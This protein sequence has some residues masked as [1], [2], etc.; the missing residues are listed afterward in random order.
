M[1]CDTLDNAINIVTLNLRSGCRA[2]FAEHF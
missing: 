2:F 1:L